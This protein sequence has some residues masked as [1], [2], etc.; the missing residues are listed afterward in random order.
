ME[1]QVYYPK[2]EDEDV[3]SNSPINPSVQCRGMATNSNT[4]E[5]AEH[6]PSQMAIGKGASW[7]SPGRTK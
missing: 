6:C 5:K 7:V 1:E 4:N 2:G 3:R